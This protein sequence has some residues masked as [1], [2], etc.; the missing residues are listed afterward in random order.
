MIKI[1]GR[2]G[3][4]IGSNNYLKNM[5]N[6]SELI[7]ECVE[8]GLSVDIQV[9]SDYVVLIGTFSESEIEY[10]NRHYSVQELKLNESIRIFNKR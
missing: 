1:T 6:I 3:N 9:F 5:G 7:G 2:N 4:R 8:M 10:F